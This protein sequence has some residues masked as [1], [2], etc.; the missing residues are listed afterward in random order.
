MNATVKDEIKAENVHHTNEINAR[1]LDQYHAMLNSFNTQATL[2]VGFALNSINHD[3]LSALA[4]DESKYCIYTSGRYFFG[5]LFGCSTVSCISISLTCIMASFYI[6]IR[7]QQY[8]L[9]VGVR[10]AVAMV[11]VWAKFIVGVYVVGLLCYFLSALSLIWIFMGG[12]NTVPAETGSVDGDTNVVQLDTGEL[13]Q[14][15]LNPRL[16]SSHEQQRHKS[17]IFAYLTSSIFLLTLV[18][19]GAFLY[20]LS[21][22]FNRVEKE[23][24]RVQ[25]KARLTA[26]R[27]AQIPSPATSKREV[28]NEGR[29]IWHS[30]ARARRTINVE[31]I[32]RSNQRPETEAPRK[33]G[34]RRLHWFGVGALTSRKGGHA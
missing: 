21:E 19:G 18:F 2:I 23:M 16:A 22:D 32:S 10:E 8:A 7:T 9:H 11:R 33:R 30:G 14:T 17:M 34:G 6:T 31:A 5:Y 24:V 20:R 4:S 15:C 29:G 12:S 13:R 25:G 28:S 26:M 3:N 27:M 1:N